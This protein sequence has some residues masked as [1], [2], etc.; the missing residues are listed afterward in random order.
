M[1]SQEKEL[2]SASHGQLTVFLRQETNNSFRVQ[3][4]KVWNSLDDKAK[5]ARNSLNCSYLT[6]LEMSVIIKISNIY[7]LVTNSIYVVGISDF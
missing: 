3:S 1:V 5:W 6:F 2:R 7:L 4:K